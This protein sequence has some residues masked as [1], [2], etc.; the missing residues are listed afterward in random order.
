MK[1]ASFIFIILQRLSLIL[2][3]AIV[4][5]FNVF[6]L[7]IRSLNSNW[8]SLCLFLELLNLKFDVIVR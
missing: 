4:T 6:H 1:F 7:N 2:D 5:A 3:I 8:R